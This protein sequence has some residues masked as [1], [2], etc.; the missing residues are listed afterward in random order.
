MVTDMMTEAGSHRWQQQKIN[1]VQMTEKLK[2]YLQTQLDLVVSISSSQLE[3]MLSIKGHLA[4]P[5]NVSGYHIWPW[6]SCYGQLVGRGRNAKHPTLHK[7]PSTM[8][9]YPAPNV[10]CALSHLFSTCLVFAWLYSQVRAPD[11]L[12]MWPHTASSNN[13]QSQKPLL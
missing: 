12:A 2:S 11:T 4:T 10:S 8:E 5:G 9:N 7:T 3:T 6:G 1:I 13:F